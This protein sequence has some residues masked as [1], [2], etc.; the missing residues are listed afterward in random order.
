MQEQVKK[1]AERRAD[2]GQAARHLGIDTCP[3]VGKRPA[4]N[5]G[6]TRNDAVSSVVAIGIQ[7]PT[8]CF[9]VSALLSYDGVLGRSNA[10]YL[11]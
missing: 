5:C 8:L 2:N 11:S 6:E 7:A 3:A 10:G 9:Q 4:L 1:I